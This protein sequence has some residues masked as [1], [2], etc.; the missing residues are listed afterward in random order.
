M[1]HAA[2]EP[3]LQ[4]PAQHAFRA[5]DGRPGFGHGIE[6]GQRFAEQANHR[7]AAASFSLELKCA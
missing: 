5:V 1:R 2:L 7:A 3:M 6:L 4:R